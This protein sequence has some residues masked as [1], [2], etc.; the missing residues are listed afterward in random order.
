MQKKL[1]CI[2]LVNDRYAELAEKWVKDKL[3]QG[4]S[5]FFAKF[6]PYLMIFQSFTAH[7]TFVAVECNEGAVKL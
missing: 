1:T 3:E 6:L 5:S 4:F 2:F 7:S